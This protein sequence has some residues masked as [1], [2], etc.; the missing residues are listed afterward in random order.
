MEATDAADTVKEVG[1]DSK[2]ATGLHKVE[3]GRVRG[4]RLQ[5]ETRGSALSQKVLDRLGAVNRRPVPEDQQLAGN[6]AE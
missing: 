4:Q 5:L 6:L 2:V 1:A 3:L